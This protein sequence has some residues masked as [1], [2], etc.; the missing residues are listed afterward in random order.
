MVKER[1]KLFQLIQR[2]SANIVGS[3]F[4]PEM[5]LSSVTAGKK[6]FVKEITQL[7]FLIHY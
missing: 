5:S 3:G 1:K 7:G 4:P 2:F 6:L